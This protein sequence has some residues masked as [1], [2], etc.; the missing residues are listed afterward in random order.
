M[1]TRSK[2]LLIAPGDIVRRPTDRAQGVVQA[3]Q[4][5]WSVRVK[6]PSGQIETVRISELIRVV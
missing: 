5:V 2:T 4:G 6:W 1:K 3:R